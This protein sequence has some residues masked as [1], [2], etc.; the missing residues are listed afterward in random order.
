MDGLLQLIE[1]IIGEVKSALDLS[2]EE[3]DKTFR[4]NL[5]GSWLVSKYVCTLIRD[6]H[7]RGSVINISSIVAA[8]RGQL[9]GCVAYASSK[10][11]IVTMT[12]VMAIELG[13][14]NIRLNSILPG[15]FNSEITEGLM[16]K[17]WLSNVAKRTVPLRTYGTSNPALTS[18]IRYLIHDGSQYVTGNNF[19]VDA[20]ATLPGVPI[21]SSLWVGHGEDQVCVASYWL[22]RIG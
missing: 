11:A 10:S 22:Q 4:T 18:I 16:K 15:L 13:P 3:W 14:Y 17:E 6:S 1:W 19:I 8:G 20:G 7:A 12:K 5:S 21:F 9:P 2:E